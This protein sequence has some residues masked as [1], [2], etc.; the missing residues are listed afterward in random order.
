MVRIYK[1]EIP[2]LMNNFIND[3]ENE[4]HILN[5]DDI[6]NHER[7]TFLKMGIIGILEKTFYLENPK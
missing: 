7:Y 5:L 2:G 6:N 4:L 3:V 1:H